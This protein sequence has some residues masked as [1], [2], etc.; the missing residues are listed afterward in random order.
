MPGLWEHLQST[1]R[2]LG[3]S[4]SRLSRP[5]ERAVN[6]SV[7]AVKGDGCSHLYSQHVH[8]IVPIDPPTCRARRARSGDTPRARVCRETILHALRAVCARS[9][10]SQCSEG[11]AKVGMGKKVAT[12]AP[13]HQNPFSD[14]TPGGE[15]VAPSR[16][17]RD[18]RVGPTVTSPKPTPHPW[19]QARAAGPAGT[20]RKLAR[21]RL[22]RRLN[23]NHVGGDRSGPLGVRRRLLSPMQN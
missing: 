7:G 5:C 14:S 21:H 6:T 18:T 15:R 8:S 22:G 2:A 23:R 9:L 12:A 17:G 11:A 13:G 19:P 10:G 16:A 3:K 1:L 20:L 4:V